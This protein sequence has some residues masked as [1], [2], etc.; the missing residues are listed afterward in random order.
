MHR[1]VGS[2]LNVGG[3]R[4]AVPSSLLLLLHANPPSL[5]SPFFPSLAEDEA[6]YMSLEEGRIATAK[7]PWRALLLI[8][9]RNISVE[10]KKK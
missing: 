10:K 9:L 4:V 3:K 7:F 1:C 8:S 6:C 2:G 5:H